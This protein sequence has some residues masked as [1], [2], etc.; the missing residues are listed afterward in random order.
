MNKPLYWIEN[1]NIEG[2][3]SFADKLVTIDKSIGEGRFWVV[4]LGRSVFMIHIDRLRLATNADC[5]FY[6]QHIQ[7]EIDNL[8]MALDA[9]KERASE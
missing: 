1:L 2:D 7:R 6:T 9:L 5:A 8:Q 4:S 3:L